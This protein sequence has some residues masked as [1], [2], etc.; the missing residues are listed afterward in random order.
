MLAIDALEN[1]WYASGW[2]TLVVKLSHA[3]KSAPIRKG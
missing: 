2:P 1:R 3:Q